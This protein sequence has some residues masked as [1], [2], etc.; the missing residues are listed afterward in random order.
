MYLQGVDVVFFGHINLLEVLQVRHVIVL[1][2]SVVA[3]LRT[4]TRSHHA[5][6]A[7][8][9]L[10]VDCQLGIAKLAGD[11]RRKHAVRAE[12]PVVPAAYLASTDAPCRED[13]LPF[14]TCR[15]HLH[16]EARSLLDGE[17]QFH[18][19]STF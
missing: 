15:P 9:Y 3:E 7:S 13:A 8:D 14:G 6:E 5:T 10:V 18:S 17:H 19:P 1:G 2:G 16:R 12:H 4:S 11:S